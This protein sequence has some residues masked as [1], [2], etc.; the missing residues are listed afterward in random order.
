QVLT[1]E[2]KF[3]F[4]GRVGIY[5]ESGIPNMA[6]LSASNG[7]SL[8]KIK[9]YAVYVM[10]TLSMDAYVVAYNTLVEK[11]YGKYFATSF[12]EL[13]EIV[14]AMTEEVNALASLDEVIDYM[15]EEN[16][17]LQAQ[18]AKFVT[19]STLNTLAQDLTANHLIPYVA[20][21]EDGHATTKNA[22]G[23]VLT[24]NVFE[25]DQR[26][27]I[28]DAFRLVSSY[29]K[30]LYG[31][32]YDD[33][34]A[35]GNATA[36]EYLAVGDK[37]VDDIVK[38]VAINNYE[39]YYWYCRNTYGAD[40]VYSEWWYLWKY[41]GAANT[42]YAYTGS[43]SNYSWPG[44]WRLPE[45]LHNIPNGDS[46]EACTAILQNYS[47]MRNYQTIRNE[48]VKYTVNLSLNGGSGVETHYD[49]TAN[50]EFVLPV[51]TKENAEFD[52]WYVSRFFY[53][54]PIEKVAVGNE[55]DLVL[56][57]KW[58]EAEAEFLTPDPFFGDGMVLPRNKAFKV[59]G[60]GTD[61]MKVTVTFAGQEKTAT[62]ENGVW[63]VSLDACEAS[64]VGAP[65]TV[66]G[67][68]IE[69]VFNNVLVGE[70]WLGAGQSNME[71]YIIWLG[72]KFAGGYNKYD[73]YDKVRLY[74]Q[75]VIG[76]DE[77]GIE[78]YGNRWLVLN[79][80]NRVKDALSHSALALAY[81]LELQKLINVPVGVVV[82]SRGG[83]YIEEWLSPETNEKLGSTAPDELNSRYYQMTV[84][85]K[86]IPFAGVLWCHGAN[87]CEYPELYVEQFK[88]LCS[89][90]RAFF[91]NGNLPVIVTQSQQYLYMDF[92]DFRMMQWSLMDKVD[93]VYVV[94]IA[95][96]GNWYDIHP[97]DKILVGARAANVAAK[98]VYDVEDANGISAYPVKIERR[99]NDIVISFS[100]AESGLIYKEL[101]SGFEVAGA[102]GVFIPCIATVEGNT[103]VLK[104]VGEGVVQVRYLYAP[105]FNSVDLYTNNGLPVAPFWL[106]I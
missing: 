22:D 2:S 27:Y 44:D 9:E 67:G 21:G 11:S 73:N 82:S 57:A 94:C 97:A 5:Q 28:P 18:I 64:F 95:D 100:N 25:V 72:M 30:G 49:R 48:N 56:Y 42:G 41:Y 37:Y 61:G 20:I 66:K 35:N 68:S 69:Y 51:P 70:I 24:T 32:F 16:N 83:T 106:Q 105:V 19:W 14:I 91:E 36:A 1:Y 10:A 47:W 13:N 34:T 60:E 33:L 90:Y 75:S 81:A 17:A 4:G 104:N 65:L 101:I 52:G 54:D 96:T 55:K 58:N 98:Y 43:V 87:N 88:A 62:V 74:R 63:S 93:N 23:T 50:E 85:L 7:M 80:K 76:I 38:A 89:Q 40:S 84:D 31:Y 12:G 59:W 102:D 6:T 15:V 8:Q 53:G 46:I 29:G 45:G 92:K 86:G 78:P 79:N 39:F 26:W 71:Y 103:V 3:E 77:A 99:G